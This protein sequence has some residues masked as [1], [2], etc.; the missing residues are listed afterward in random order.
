MKRLIMTIIIAVLITSLAGCVEYR[1]HHPHAR[2]VVVVTKPNHP[3][4]PSA[5]PRNP[6]GHR[7]PTP[8]LRR[9]HH[10]Y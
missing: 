5:Y 9:D 10:R 6:R 7:A 3:P 1:H 2:Q 8:M 4:V